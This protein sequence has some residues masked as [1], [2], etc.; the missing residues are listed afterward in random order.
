VTGGDLFRI[1][2]I[3]GL[4]AG[5]L[6][7]ALDFYL[8][9]GV[10]SHEGLRDFPSLNTE[11]GPA[12]LALKKMENGGCIFLKDNLCMIHTIRPIV[13][14]SF[15]FVFQDAGDHR[16]WGLSAMKDICP[17]LGTGPEMIGSDLIEL[18]DTVLEDLIIF[19]EFAEEWNLVEE[20]TAQKL[21][22][23]ILSDPRFSA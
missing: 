6:M 15:P 20:P 14:M 2:T 1:S 4:V 3:L 9:S 8:V 17:G 13:C 12:Y 23:T 18:A 22:E 21:I 7:K 11:K 5:E 16:K 19:N 10:A